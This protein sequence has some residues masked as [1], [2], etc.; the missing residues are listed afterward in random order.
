VL[1]KNPGGKA[2]SGRILFE[3]DAERRSQIV[4][5]PY[6]VGLPARYEPASPGSIVG[7]N[8]FID[9]IKPTSGRRPRPRPD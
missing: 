3:D 7:V 8:S 5:L 1:D 9:T 2:A 6:L 4:G